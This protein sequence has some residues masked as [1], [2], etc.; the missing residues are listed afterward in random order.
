PSP[1]GM[2]GKN[3]FGKVGYGGPCPPGGTH[4]YFFTLYA[5]DI[6]LDVSPGLD[7]QELLNTI[8]GHVLGKAQLMGTYE[9]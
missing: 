7:K 1:G 2:Q 5:L 9:R 3:S 8:G 4:R 6:Q